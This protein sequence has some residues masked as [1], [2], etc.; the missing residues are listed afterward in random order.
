[1]QFIILD[2]SVLVS[3]DLKPASADRDG[4][5]VEFMNMIL[6]DFMKNEI[7]ILEIIYDCSKANFPCKM[8]THELS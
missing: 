1:M 5:K 7:K 2:R 8:L 3:A 4:A 6:N